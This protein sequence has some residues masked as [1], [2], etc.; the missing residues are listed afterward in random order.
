MPRATLDNIFQK[1][2]R[3]ESLERMARNKFTDPP[4]SVAEERVARAASDG[5]TADCRDLGGDEDL[6]NV[7]GTPR[8]LGEQWPDTR[9]IRAD[10]IRWL[11]VDR[12]AREQVD[13]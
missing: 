12:E 3:M 8:P 4:L 5:T 11:C 6:Q 2:D 9:N 10:L 13:P 1:G 7:D